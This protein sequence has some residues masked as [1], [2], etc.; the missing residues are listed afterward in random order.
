M[1]HAM[2]A[3]RIYAAIY[4]RTHHKIPRHSSSS[5][6]E[7]IQ[8]Q[9]I[10]PPPPPKKIRKTDSCQSLRVFYIPTYS[11]TMWPLC[12]SPTG[13]GAGVVELAR[14]LRASSHLHSC[15]SLPRY[16]GA[17]TIGLAVARQVSAGR[18]LRGAEPPRPAHGNLPRFRPSLFT[19]LPVFSLVAPFTSTMEKISMLPA[20]SVSCDKKQVL[21]NKA[22]VNNR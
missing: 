11:R 8:K 18:S 3:V 17:V 15:S 20:A 19:R 6:L 7:N 2:F 12:W 4:P 14:R 9:H 5:H 16:R 22:D 13:R 10:P 21:L 1:S